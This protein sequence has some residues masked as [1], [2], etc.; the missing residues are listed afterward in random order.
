MQT[1]LLPVS[2]ACSQSFS[3]PALETVSLSDC[4][5]AQLEKTSLYVATPECALL[6]LG[7][8]DL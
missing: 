1:P 6:P 2:L 5:W 3:L 4:S 7:S 8:L